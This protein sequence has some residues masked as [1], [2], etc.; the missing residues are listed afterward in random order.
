MAEAVMM[1][2]TQKA[3]TSDVCILAAVEIGSRSSLTSQIV[4]PDMLTLVPAAQ[5]MKTNLHKWE[6]HYTLLWNRVQIDM[7][8]F[9]HRTGIPQVLAH[10]IFHF[11]AP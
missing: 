6:S 9:M 1:D 2:H 7:C 10:N 5:G 3:A 8:H 11:P 4:T